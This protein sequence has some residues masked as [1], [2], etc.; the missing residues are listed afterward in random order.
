LDKAMAVAEDLRQFIETV[1]SVSQKSMYI[2]L[3]GKIEF[4][5][6]D[7]PKAIEYY[8][9]ALNMTEMDRMLVIP[10]NEYL[11][12]LA[13]AYY[14]SGDLAKAKVEFSKIN[15]GENDILFA[16][17]RQLEIIVLS[18]YML[19]KISE[20]QGDTAEA[21]EFYTKFLTFRKDADPGLPKVDDAKKRLAGLRE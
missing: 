8:E 1:K 5:Q 21:I 12:S 20:Q 13:E 18:T 9:K 3:I 16:W 17:E 7:I 6:G 15:I 2:L 19:G 4:A 11:Y 14:R 10:L